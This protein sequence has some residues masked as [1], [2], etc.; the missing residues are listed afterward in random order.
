VTTVEWIPA[1]LDDLTRIW[2][3]ADAATRARVTAAADR[4][5]Q[6]IQRDPNAES[7]SRG[8]D[9][10][11]IVE[12]PLTAYFLFDPIRDIATI[13]TARFVPKRTKS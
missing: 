3:K 10:H 4:L 8:G 9:S 13:F 5:E 12:L 1:A 11:V 2:T 7:E 6:R